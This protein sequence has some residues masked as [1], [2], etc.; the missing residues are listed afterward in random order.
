MHK[1]GRGVIAG[2]YSNII[3]H[4]CV[5]SFDLILH[6]VFL[7][8]MNHILGLL[9]RLEHPAATNLALKIMRELIYLGLGKNIGVV[10]VGG[11]VGVNVGVRVRVG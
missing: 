2:F 7:A 6:F 5:P 4:F 9:S 10:I 1:M 11:L 8:T 3:I